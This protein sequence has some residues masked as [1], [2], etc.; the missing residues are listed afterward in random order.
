MRE[1]P[2][3]ARLR[4]LVA[5]FAILSLALAACNGDDGGEA[6]EEAT[7]GEDTATED[8]EG[9]E[10]G[11]LGLEQE[12]LILVG[13]DIDFAPFEFIEDGEAR[14]FDIDLMTEIANRLDLEVEFV[15]TSF[16]TIFTQLAAGE[17]DAIISGITIT[18][19]REET[20]AFS[21]P[22]FAANQA[23]VVAADS[24]ISSTEDLEGAD[25]GVQSATTGADYANEN[26]AGAN[27]VEF[28]TSPAGFNALESGQLD[29]FFI[30]L[31]V[32]AENTE[33]NDALELVEEVDTDELYGI[34]VQQD[35]QALVDAINT[36]LQAI[37]DDGTYEEFY[38]TWFEGDVPEQFRS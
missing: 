26:F 4:M 37:I 18:E 38:S 24:E 10:T 1:T 5:L 34:G 15:N 31:P 32:A 2:L 25:V 3:N 22:Y 20:I 19:E 23:L 28:P 8:A 6:G 21:D 9:G 16:D 12:G 7:P 35:N 14:G 11:D 13:S 33:G 36:Q 29:A 17:F 30:D 27:I